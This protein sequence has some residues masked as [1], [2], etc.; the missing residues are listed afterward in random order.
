[1][2]AGVKAGYSD[3][4]LFGDEVR[5]RKKRGAELINRQALELG[6]VLKADIHKYL[7]AKAELGYLQKGGHLKGGGW[8]YQT[9][10]QVNYLSIPLLVGLSPI[11]TEP[12]TLSF[13]AGF[14]YNLLMSSDIGYSKD[15]IAGYRAEETTDIVSQLVGIELATDVLDNLTLFANYRYSKDRD[16]FHARVNSTTGENYDLWNKGNSICFGVR[17][18]GKNRI[19]TGLAI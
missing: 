8:T 17:F 19:K 13:E 18:K 11:K 9:P 16:F 12:V 1:M 4:T 15:I 14:A 3:Y 10:V 2:S 5:L 6:F 7:Y